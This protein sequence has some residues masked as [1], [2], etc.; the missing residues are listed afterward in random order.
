[1]LKRPFVNV[2]VLST[3]LIL[4]AG[5][6]IVRAAGMRAADQGLVANVDMQR[7][8][9]E[10]DVRKGIELK[11]QEFGANLGKHFDEVTKTP[12]LGPDEIS[13]LSAALNAEKPTDADKK[14]IDTI[15]GESQKRVDEAQRMAALKQ[16][17]EKDLARIRELEAMQRQRPLYQERLQKVY[18]QAIDEEETR[19][20][21]AGMAEVRVI[22]GK[23]ARDQGFGQV[24]DVTAMVY[25][26][27]D[28]TDQA[29]RKVQTNKKK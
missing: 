6:Y 3:A 15:K 25:A 23:L 12:Y 18:Q 13:D 16:P 4:G 2:L 14:K 8:F 22:V 26:S 11:L 9:V 1:M 28:L 21:R 20:M 10:S 27:S 17:A 24:F 19:R 5:S 7:V 29:I